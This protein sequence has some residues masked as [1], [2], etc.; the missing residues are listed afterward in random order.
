MT[1]LLD[2]PLDAA[3]LLRAGALVAF[4]TETVYGLGA[5]ARNA[6]AVAEIF[7]AKGRPHFNP[8]I[9][10]FADADSAFAEVRA[11]ARARA[12][13]ARFWPGPLTLVL[14]RRADCRVELLAGAGLDTL[15]VRVPAHDLALAML[16]A[17]G[18]PVAAP[19][20]NRS[21]RVS[22]TSPAHVMEELG[23]RIA[24]ILDGG[25]CAVGVES[26]VLD[27]GAGGAALLRPGGVPVEAIEAVIGPVGRPLSPEAAPAP[28]LRSP[29]LLL[30]H[31]APVLP[32]RLDAREVAADE[33]LLAFGPPL[34]GAAITEQL[35]LA[36]DDREAARRLF[37]A[38]RRLDAEGRRLGLR[39]IAAMPV[40]GG[41]LAPAIR[42]RL[43][44]A[45][46]PRG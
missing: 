34:A 1:A 36:R 3:A 40:P 42:D 21:G 18:G 6:A 17:F 14:P 31:Y 23:G 43:A 46:A 4:P 45:A 44:R 15:A 26:T 37:G 7:A 5:D 22:P 29:G 35:S 33:A 20:A 13:A 24:A 39:G 10:H 32:L 12:L 41:G 38:L 25:E 9:C 27:L 28:T 30:S 19:S 2:D 11:D 16:R 8:L